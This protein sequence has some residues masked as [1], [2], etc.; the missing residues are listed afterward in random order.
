MTSPPTWTTQVPTDMSDDDL[1]LALKTV[2]T[3]QNQLTPETSNLNLVAYSL[4]YEVARRFDLTPPG[5]APVGYPSDWVA[6]YPSWPAD[7]DDGNFPS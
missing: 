1:A 2:H 3:R 7:P 4:Q 6:S 5:S